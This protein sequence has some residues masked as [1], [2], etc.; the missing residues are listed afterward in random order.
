VV[1]QIRKFNIKLET[2]KGI[3]LFYK[4]EKKYGQ[5]IE[6]FGNNLAGLG[7][8]MSILVSLM[9]IALFIFYNKATGNV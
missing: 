2:H 8:I 4:I 5:L 6:V 7:V 1:L 9:L 3:N